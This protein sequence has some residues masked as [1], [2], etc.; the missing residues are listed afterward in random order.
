MRRTAV[1]YLH[2]VW[3]HHAPGPH[4]VQERSALVPDDAQHGLPQAEQVQ[5]TLSVQGGPG[6]ACSK[7]GRKRSGRRTHRQM[8]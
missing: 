1:P 4:H 8:N 3:R 6:L 5:G 7:T 2:Q